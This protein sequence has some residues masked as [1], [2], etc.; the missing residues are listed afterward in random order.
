MSTKIYDNTKAKHFYIN[1]KPQSVTTKALLCVI[2][3]KKSPSLCFIYCLRYLLEELH[4]DSNFMSV[5]II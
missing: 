4:V 5:Q 3:K 1:Y 2:K